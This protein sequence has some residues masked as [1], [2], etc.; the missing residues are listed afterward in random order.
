LGEGDRG[1]R[2]FVQEITNTVSNI[3]KQ[4]AGVHTL[5]MIL[6]TIMAVAIWLPINPYQSQ[7][8]PSLF[9][10]EYE[11]MVYDDIIFPEQFA[12]VRDYEPEKYLLSKVDAKKVT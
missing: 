2:L 3:N 1:R 9:R 8:F 7:A 5:R 6:E 4:N 10:M 12:Y 11:R